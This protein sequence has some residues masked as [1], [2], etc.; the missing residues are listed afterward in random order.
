M[1]GPPKAMCQASRHS[2]HREDLLLLKTFMCQRVAPHHHAL[3]PK[4]MTSSSKVER[5]APLGQIV[6]QVR[7][8]LG[9][10]SHYQGRPSLISLIWHVGPW[11]PTCG[12]VAPWK[13]KLGLFS[14]NCP[15]TSSCKDKLTHP[16]RISSHN[17]MI[18]ESNR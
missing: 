15:P 6:W 9:R 18:S 7:G 12:L 1:N 13:P 5:F 17:I 8:V 16:P 14:Q 4:I 2:Y 10:P 3:A 11:H